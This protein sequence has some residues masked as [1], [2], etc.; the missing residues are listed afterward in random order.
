MHLLSKEVT[1]ERSIAGLV[2]LQ[3]HIPVCGERAGKDGDEAKGALER[4]V[5]DVAHLVFE[6]LRRD[7]GIEEILAQHG[8]DLSACSSAHWLALKRLPE[9]VDTASSRLGAAIDEHAVR[10]IQDLAESLEEPPMRIDL[11]LI[12]LLEAE[13]HLDGGV[14]LLDLDNVVLEIEPHLGGVFINMRSDIL[15]VDLLLRDPILVHT[16]GCQH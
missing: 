2:V 14:A 7:Q 5:E 4:L 1:L 12:L 16:H 13:Q 6:V 10:G 15:A 8:L 11:L 9:V 3:R